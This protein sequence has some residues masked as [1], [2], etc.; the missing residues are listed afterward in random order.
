MWP[1]KRQRE[2]A[3]GPHQRERDPPPCVPD[4]G[5]GIPPY[6]REEIEKRGKQFGPLLW[7][8]AF[9]TQPSHP[10]WPHARHPPSATVRPT[11]VN[12]RNLTNRRSQLGFANTR[13]PQG[14][15]HSVRVRKIRD[16]E[17][18]RGLVSIGHRRSAQVRGGACHQN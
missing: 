13:T 1:R 11:P 14:H 18:L 6:K 16:L 15:T 17:S 12:P 8:P 2:P 5:A 4:S 3:A 9:P 10:F 7:G